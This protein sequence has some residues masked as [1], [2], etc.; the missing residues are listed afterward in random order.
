[1]EELYKILKTTGLPVAYSHFTRKAEPPF[2]VYFV[3]GEDG[4]FADNKIYAKLIDYE[5]E[6]YTKNK[7]LESEKKIEEVLEKNQI[8]YI[9]ETTWINDEKLYQVVFYI[10]K[11][12]V[13]NE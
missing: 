11:M 2:V 9:K 8:N 7:D 4:I 13:E 5:I 1:M 3:D 6:L 12:E 10:Q